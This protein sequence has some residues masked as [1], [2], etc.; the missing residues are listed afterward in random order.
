MSCFVC[1]RPASRERQRNEYNTQYPSNPSAKSALGLNRQGSFKY[2]SYQVKR[3]T[4]SDSQVNGVHQVNY[5]DFKLDLEQTESPPNPKM[6]ARATRALQEHVKDVTEKTKSCCSGKSSVL[7]EN[8][9]INTQTVVNNNQY[10]QHYHQMQQAPQHV[11]VEPLVYVTDKTRGTTYLRGRLLGKVI[12]SLE[13]ASSRNSDG[14]WFQTSGKTNTS[15]WALHLL[16]CFSAVQRTGLEEFRLHC[17]L[18]ISVG[19]PAQ[20]SGTPTCDKKVLLIICR[21]AAE[22]HSGPQ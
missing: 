8:M 10:N 18:P 11:S 16:G 15:I 4:D 9:V 17:F 22:L 2:S 3:C 1:C 7:K 12:I 5:K 19:A 14:P 6:L 21:T 20:R 13:I